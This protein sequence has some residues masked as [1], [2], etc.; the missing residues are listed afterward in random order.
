M[1]SPP[2]TLYPR[3]SAFYLFYFG[4]LGALVPYWGLYLQG[5]AF[6]PEQIGQLSAIFSTTRIIAPNIWGWIGDHTGRG[7]VVVRFACGLALISFLGVLGTEDFAGL[8]AVMVSFTFFWNAALP[9]TEAT[10]LNHLGPRR[11][12]SVRLWGSIG[13]IIAVLAMGLLLDYWGISYLPWVLIGF[14]LA[15]WLTSL[16]VPD[17]PR[18]QL[19]QKTESL[20]YILLRWEVWAFLLMTLLMQA[21]HGP[22]YTFFS[23]HLS[24][25]NYPRIFISGLWALGVLAEIGVFLFMN[26]WISRH[27]VQWI[28][29]F[30]M[31][32]A[33]L[34]WVIIGT[35]A[36]R[37]LL[38]LAAQLLHGATF[39]AYH[40]AAIHLV[41]QYF[42]GRYQVRGQA[43]YGSLGFGAGGALGSLYS[44]Y[45]WQGWGAEITFC[46]AALLS[47]VA[48]G[49]AR[50]G[51]T[52]MVRSPSPLPQ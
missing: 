10:V 32:L 9:Q 29:Q 26:R 18:P 43:L 30:V 31:I 42:T 21:S 6:Q 24:Q 40:G 12:S 52:A 23:I 34:R 25:H 41:H 5:L 38:L 36:D 14:Y 16:T 13:F 35:C 15:L 39:G 51:I 47:L 48:L 45:A 46:S 2:R 44:G 1:E 3:L 50:W 33:A 19:Q 20:R 37:P 11:Y 17:A 8:A 28:L 22:Y 27:G 4:S 49:L 7:M